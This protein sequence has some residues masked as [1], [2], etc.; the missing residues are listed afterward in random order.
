MNTNLPIV[1]LWTILGFFCGSL[2]FS[3][4]VGQLITH[5]DIR[6]IGDYNPGATNVLRAGGW[7]AGLLALLLDVTKG[8]LP[9]GLAHY[10]FSYNGFGLI[11]IALSPTLG[12][13]FSPFLNWQGGKALAVTLGVWIGL[14]L[15]EI[16]L[17]GLLL[18]VLF[19]TT[20]KSDAWS[21]LFTFIGIG[22]YLIIFN[23]DPILISILCLQCIV[24][25]YK[26][27]SGYFQ[28]PE[29][30]DWVVKLFDRNSLS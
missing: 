10:T 17:V 12:H 18:I 30:R 16:P 2:P 4:W 5:R 25:I 3:Y 20:F 11:P 8:A 26:H 9:V 1:L 15:F 13:A 21:V 6:Q 14:T 22:V 29:F 27:R 19:F 7:K 23:P 24:I 28:R